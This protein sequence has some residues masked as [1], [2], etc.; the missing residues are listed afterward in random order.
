MKTLYHVTYTNTR[1]NTTDSAPVWAES[2]DEAKKNVTF[3]APWRVVDE[4][5]EVNARYFERKLRG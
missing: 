4:V 3:L 5:E 2:I 1:T